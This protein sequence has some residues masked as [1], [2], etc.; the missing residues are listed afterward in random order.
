ML[1]RLN[2]GI[3]VAAIT[4]AVFGVVT[5]IEGVIGRTIGAV[6]ASLLEH[7]I[8]GLISIPAIVILLT[9][10][11]LDWEDT[12]SVL[13][14]SAIVAVLV[15]AGVAGVAYSMPRIGVTAGN[16]AILFG[17][18]GIVL[19]IDTFGIGGYP[20]IPLSIPRIAGLLLMVA[21]IFLVLPRDS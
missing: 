18:M 20:R 12:R 21:G 14:L 13:P 2:S 8:A 7:A 16:M 9:S 3:G 4:G 11:R 6:N 1:Q 15:I 5:A 10:R 17:Q 19:L